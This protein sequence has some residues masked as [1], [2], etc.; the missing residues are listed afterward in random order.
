MRGCPVISRLFRQ[1]E[2]RDGQTAAGRRSLRP[3]GIPEPGMTFNRFKIGFGSD[4]QNIRCAKHIR[5]EEFVEAFKR[6]MI[7]D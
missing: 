4:R 7:S 2:R 5:A 1:A 3:A 6:I